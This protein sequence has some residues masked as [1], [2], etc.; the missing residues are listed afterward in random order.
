MGIALTLRLLRAVLLGED[1]VPYQEQSLNLEIV[2]DWRESLIEVVNAIDGPSLSRPR[3][4][5]VMAF[6]IYLSIR[7]L[8]VTSNDVT[9]TIDLYYYLI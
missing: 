5:G 1:L 8:T 4:T 2:Q 7:D 3:M 9:P 6:T